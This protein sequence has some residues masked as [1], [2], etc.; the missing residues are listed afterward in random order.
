VSEFTEL[1][2]AIKPLLEEWADVVSFD[3]PGVGREPLPEGISAIDQW[4]RQVVVDRGLEKLAEAGWDRFFVAT[5]GWGIASAVGIATRRRDDVAG[6]CLGHAK[7]SYSREGERAPI[8]A[9][10]YDTFT[11]LVRQDTPSFIRYGIAQVTKGGIDEDRAERIIERMPAENMIDGW[12]AFTADDPF[13]E[14]LLGLDLPLLLAKHEGCLISTD[15]GFEDAVA[16]LPEAETAVFDV[17]PVS[18]PEF[19]AVLRSFC[20]KHW[21]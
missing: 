1:E 20:E 15:E 5:E 11:Q 17:S 8:N 2:W 4:T 21:K 7:L 12:E 16:A 14:N 13:R 3:A 10:V 9:A 18:S 6:M 19:A